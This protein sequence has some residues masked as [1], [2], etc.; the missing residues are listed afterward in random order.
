MVNSFRLF[1]SEFENKQI[2]DA[3]NEG[4]ALYDRNGTVM[5]LN[6]YI[7]ENFTGQ[8]AVG[9]NAYDL[10]RDEYDDFC[11]IRLQRFET[12][13]QNNVIVAHVDHLMDR[14]F[15]N[16]L[17]PISTDGAVRYLLI[18]TEDITE[19]KKAEQLEREAVISKE[20]EQEYLQIIDGST[21][22]SWIHD[23]NHNT[24]RFSQDWKKRIGADDISDHDMHRYFDTIVHPEDLI[25]NEVRRAA[26]FKNKQVKFKHEYRIKTLAG[27]YIWISDQGKI[28]YNEDG[29]PAKV[30]GTTMDINEAKSNEEALKRSEQRAMDLV[31]QL[32]KADKNKNEYLGM[33][34]HEL[35]NPLAAISVG[36]S[37][38]E[39][40]D[41]PEYSKQIYQIISRQ[42][43][44]LCRLVDELLDITRINNNKIDLKKELTD[45]V[46]LA[47]NT[48][49]DLKPLFDKK[50]IGLRIEVPDEL[51]IL[52]D[53]VRIK[54][55]I[56]NLLYNALNYT[57]PGGSAALS[58]RKADHE[59]IISVKD[60]GT[61]LKP[62]EIPFIF[63]PFIQ[64]DKSP[65][66]SHS[67]LGLGLVIVKTIAELHG[68]RV[69]AYSEGPGKGAVFVL[70]IPAIS[71]GDPVPA[72]PVQAP[73]SRR[74]K[75]LHIEDNQDF[76]VLFAS[77]VR[78]LGHQ[79]DS[80]NNSPEGI[81][82][83]LHTRYDVIFCDI[84]LPGISGYEA[85]SRIKSELP[86]DCP[87][88]IALTGYAANED[89]EAA[90]RSGFDYHFSKP[91]D[92]TK[93]ET[94]L[95]TL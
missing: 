51:P 48:Y 9:D 5:F 44:Q 95:L 22:A 90:W 50:N 92:I 61:G 58:I 28:T 83:A 64:I 19:K 24:I 52:L 76:A 53:P 59:A 21:I 45:L 84:G 78:C 10:V 38:I 1:D 41:D 87:V 3:I 11:L 17:Y 80:A 89:I 62:E 77:M 88:L 37:L 69:N 29:S 13:I 18:V 27:E 72:A 32:Q 12:A 65:D 7:L 42:T 31:K 20:K 56:E 54:Q 91:I 8:I 67:G 2:L 30:F 49:D 86:H 63:E 47:R 66:R 71:P 36:L 16:R 93:L 73:P 55:S 43:R 14:W 57:N 82:M 68:G 81:A 70:H 33:L 23:W 26:L 85:A 35:R 4:V 40:A 34:S 46:M 60:S 79:V 25:T 39:A 94:L 6:K 15:D 74:L 75:I